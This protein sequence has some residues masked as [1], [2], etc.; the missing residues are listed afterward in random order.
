ML[1]QLEGLYPRAFCSRKQKAGS[2]F[3]EYTRE[4]VC[5]PYQPEATQLD[6]EEFLS[7]VAMMSSE[8]IGDIWEGRVASQIPATWMSHR[9]ANFGANIQLL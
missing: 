3:E 7:P 1:E 9:G 2:G 8:K 6:R 4:P 5:S